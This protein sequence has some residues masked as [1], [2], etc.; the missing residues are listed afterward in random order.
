MNFGRGT[1][2]LSVLFFGSKKWVTLAS[3]R[4]VIEVR[5]T[6]LSTEECVVHVDPLRFTHLV[7]VDD[8]FVL[9]CSKD[10]LFG[11]AA[12]RFIRTR[13]CL[14]DWVHVRRR[15][16]KAKGKDLVRVVHLVATTDEIAWHSE[17]W[18]CLNWTDCNIKDQ[19][20]G[21]EIKFGSMFDK[22]LG[23]GLVSSILEFSICRVLNSCGYNTSENHYLTTG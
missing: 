20:L 14:A 16:A 12:T 18:S 5:L 7:A 10:E 22:G 6:S 15:Q 3:G 11:L 9:C 1:D 19:C 13:K 21:S 23:L 4:S 17:L 2:N 8:L